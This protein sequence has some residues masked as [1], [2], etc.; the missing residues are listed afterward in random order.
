MQSLYSITDNISFKI[1]EKMWNAIF[2]YLDATMKI[3]LNSLNMQIGIKHN[4]KLAKASK[5]TWNKTK[6][7]KKWGGWFCLT[8]QSVGEKRG[9]G[10]V[11]RLFFQM[12]RT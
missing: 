12:V 10:D 7:S 1:I 8:F 2:N 4:R 5:M 9:G 6:F 3:R 11:H